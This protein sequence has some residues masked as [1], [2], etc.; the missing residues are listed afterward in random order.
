MISSSKNSF[1]INTLLAVLFLMAAL[2]SGYMLYS[3]PKELMLPAG[4][5]P[6]LSKAYITVAFTLVLGGITIYTTFRSQ[7]EIIVYK[8][9]THDTSKQESEARDDLN[10]TTISLEGVESALAKADQHKM[11]QEFIRTI[12]KQLEAGQGA[13]YLTKETEGTRKVQLESGY[14]L[15]VGE[16]ASI[17][18]EFGEGLVGQAAAEGR[19]LYVD[20]V[21]EGYIT[22]VSGLGS[23]SPRYL[24]IAPVQ[25]EDK[26]VGVIEIASFTALDEN[27]RRFIEESAQMLA[28]KINS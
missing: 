17:S 8:E 9:K 15:S 28:R 25:Q 10:K 2:L 19:T 27:K 26:V 20:D 6:V 4:M 3:L 12:C 22:I 1:T 11:F 23:A 24:L 16:S 13:L 18:F 21:P 14:A 5:E 7:R